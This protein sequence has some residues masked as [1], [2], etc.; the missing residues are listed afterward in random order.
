MAFCWP[1]GAPPSPARQLFLFLFQP[2]PV[3]LSA[4]LYLISRLWRDTTATDKLY[5]TER[6]L[7]TLRRSVGLASLA[8]AAVWVWAAWLSP[9][10]V[11]ATFAPS[12]WP[13]RSRMPDLTAFSAELFRWDEVFGLGAHL[14]WLGYLYWDLAHAG[15]LPEGWLRVMGIG[16]ASVLAVG[17][18]AT[19]GLGWL[20]R[21]QILA[22]RRHKDALTLD[23]V[24]RLHGVVA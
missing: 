5:R 16:L 13:A 11:L 7:P 1:I 2:F 18:G 4:A 8:A 17:P 23:S 19:I 24:G 12:A 14:V 15:M 3:Y 6:D 10:G 9:H 22:T 21:E 20:W